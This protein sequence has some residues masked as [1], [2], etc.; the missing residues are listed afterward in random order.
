MPARLPYGCEDGAVEDSYA[1][2]DYGPLNGNRRKRMIRI[3]VFIT[4]GAMLLPGLAGLYSV[5]AQ[6]AAR[7][8]AIATSRVAPD[9]DAASA[10]F[11]FFGPG[12]IGWECYA[13]GGF[14]GDRHII[15]LG[16]FP[17]MATLPT[18]GTPV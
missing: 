14:G 6:A 11:T 15:S 17:G 2:E 4:V 18:G 10:K 7:A 13:L 5:N 9:A 8:C 12:V 1:D 3:V 16:L